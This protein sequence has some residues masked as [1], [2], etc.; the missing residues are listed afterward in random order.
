MGSHY[1]FFRPKYAVNLIDALRPRQRSGEEKKPFNFQIRFED[2]YDDLALY[3]MNDGQRQRIRGEARS[4]EEGRDPIYTVRDMVT[5]DLVDFTS[6]KLEKNI[7]AFRAD[8]FSPVSRN[9]FAYATPYGSGRF[10]EQ[11][12][13]RKGLD[14]ERVK[15]VD[16]KIGD[17]VELAVKGVFSTF[18]LAVAINPVFQKYQDRG[19]ALVVPGKLIERE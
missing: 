12:K 19:L 18:D 17:P 8:F 4:A 5:A 15:F 1:L 2:R 13:E 7:R 11:M 3:V 6:K 10:K 16:Y 9:F 14:L